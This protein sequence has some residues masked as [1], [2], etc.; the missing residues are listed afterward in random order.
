[1]D[2]EGIARSIDNKQ[3][4]DKTVIE[5]YYNMKDDLQKQFRWVPMKTRFDKTESVQ[6]FQ[7]RYGNAY[8]I[9][10]KIWGSITNP[11]L[12]SDFATLADDAQYN[13]Y[14]KKMQERID[15]NLLALEKKKNIYYQKK[16]KL[17]EDMNS[18]N[19]FIKSNVIYT[20]C[21]AKSYDGI[22][23]KVLD[24]GCG[25]GGDIQK[26][27]YCEVELY[28]GFDPDLEGLI[29]STDSAVTRY[30]QQKALH[31]R[32]FPAFF[33]NATGCALL[34]YDEQVKVMGKLRPE[35]KKV[36]DKFL[37]WN[38]KRTI[39]DRFNYSY[40]IHYMLS[41]ENSFN[42][43][44]ENTN[45]YLRDGGIILF[46]TFDGELIREK[47]KGK[48]RLIDYYD[49]NGEKKVLYEIVKKY[50]D[51]SKDKIGLAIDVHMA[52]IMEEGVYQTEYLVLNDFIINILKEKC[53]LELIE[54]ISFREAFENNREFL[55][56]A[57]KVEVDKEKKFYSNVYKFYNDTEF[58]RK[59]QEYSFLSRYYVFRKSEKD[60]KD[61]KMKYYGSNRKRITSYKAS[62]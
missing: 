17:T 50:D 58:N 1:L 30:K 23:L 62:K 34:Q 21:N 55:K 8:E 2:D 26:W 57:S 20:Y 18:F 61:V 41:D 52:W 32:F 46:C 31:D 43:M 47:L 51:S 12:M 4:S 38:D 7:R 37:T 56:I 53:S 11:V 39:F 3:L 22:Q 54:T 10:K 24:L 13:N 16:T 40:T 25:R 59:C 5:F 44:L 27:Y 49:E 15:F 35:D 19:N 60:L 14:F 45:R 29:S 28:V 9:A 42:N 36:F 48:D 33:A 6:K